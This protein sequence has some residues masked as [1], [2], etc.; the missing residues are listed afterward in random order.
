[1]KY[2]KTALILTLIAGFCAA[3]IASVNMITAPVIEENAKLKK[4]ALCQEIFVDYDD[5]TSKTYTEGFESPYITEKIEAYNTNKEFLGY[6]YTVTGSNTYGKISL[7]VGINADNKLE[8]VKFITNEQSYKAQ[9]EN[10]LDNN[11]HNDMTLDEI[12]GLDFSKI[13][14]T[15]GATYASKLIRQLVNVAFEDAKGGNNNG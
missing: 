10:H 6:I 4:E 2:L 5:D 12:N 3:L 9:T 11:Y 15:S 8:S 14:V 13:E 7:L 1:M